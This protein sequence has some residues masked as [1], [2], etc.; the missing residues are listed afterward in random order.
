ME[1]IKKF[2]TENQSVFYVDLS[3]GSFED[4]INHQEVEIEIG[5]KCL[6]YKLVYWG[7]FEYSNTSIADDVH[8]FKTLMDVEFEINDLTFW[9][10]GGEYEKPN[11]S[12]LS[13]EEKEK[14]IKILKPYIYE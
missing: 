11:G 7:I 13:E 5:N 1:T 10:D 14:I 6:S 8:V 4:I 3:T 9:I 12:K 2:I